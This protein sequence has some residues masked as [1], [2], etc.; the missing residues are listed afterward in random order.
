M[1]SSFTTPAQAPSE[2]REP[3]KYGYCL[4]DSSRGVDRAALE[5][6]DNI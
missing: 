4:F 2:P 1:A 3:S 6:G 5:A